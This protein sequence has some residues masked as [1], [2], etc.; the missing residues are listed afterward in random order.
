M[1]KNGILNSQLNNAISLS[2]HGDILIIA[3]AGFP[4]PDGVQKIDLAIKQDLPTNLTILDLI[5]R[6]FIYE[7]VVVAKEQA[8][9]N[10]NLFQK[11]ENTIKSCPITT[12]AHEEILTQIAK[13]AKFII[14]TG[15]FEPWGN[16]VLYSGID[17]PE[18]FKKEGVIVPDDYKKRVQ[19]K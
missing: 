11:V 19:G 3:D 16:I 14:R 8:L 2:G 7:K 5:I 13:Q 18:W 4:V 17:A 1:K 15:S 6:D 9:Y 12:V 10:P